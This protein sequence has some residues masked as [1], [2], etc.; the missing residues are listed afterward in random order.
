[1]RAG[2][3]CD[4]VTS[5]TSIR[6]PAKRL[7]N[8]IERATSKRC[9]YGNDILPLIEEPTWNRIELEDGPLNKVGGTGIAKGKEDQ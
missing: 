6:Y 5:A 8:V 1:M 9:R 7:R 4:S 3:H 2:T